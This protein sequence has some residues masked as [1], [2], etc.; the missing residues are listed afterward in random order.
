MTHSIA[1][2]NLFP[3]FIGKLVGTFYESNGMKSA[4]KLNYERLLT[5][6]EKSKLDKKEFMKLYPPCN[7][8]YTSKGSRV[9]CS[10]R[11]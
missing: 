8:E 4:V 11:R 7:S 2:N 10:D 5:L 1:C 3:I 9:W 6:A